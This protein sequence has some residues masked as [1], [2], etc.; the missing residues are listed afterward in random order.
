MEEAYRRATQR[1]SERRHHEQEPKKKERN[2]QTGHGPKEHPNLPI[3][4][5]TH[6]LDEA[7]RIVKPAAILW[8]PGMVNSRNRKKST[9]LI[10]STF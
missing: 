3:V 10:F 7:D 5:V 4:E 1:G 6:E 2:P 8:I 9:S